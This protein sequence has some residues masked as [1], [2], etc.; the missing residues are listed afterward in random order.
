MKYADMLIEVNLLV[1]NTVSDAVK[2]RWLN[3]VERQVYRKLPIDDSIATIETVPGQA[4]YGL[5]SDC[6]LSNIT[7]VVIGGKEYDRDDGRRSRY[8]DDAAGVFMI[9]PAPQEVLSGI[10]LYKPTPL[11]PTDLQTTSKLPEDYHQLLIDGCAARVAQAE[12][13]WDAYR[14]YND[15]FNVML[16]DAK[17]AMS[18]NEELPVIRIE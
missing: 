3:Q 14:I 15:S 11:E 8:W 18:L 10:I 6:Q 5:P 9:I 7:S 13:K 17:R 12:Q 2:I 4:A 1:E 16:R